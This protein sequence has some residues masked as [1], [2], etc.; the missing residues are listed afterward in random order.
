MPP[1]AVAFSE[2][3]SSLFDPAKQGNGFDYQR[4]FLNGYCVDHIVHFRM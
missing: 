4:M 2:A 3:G 1:I